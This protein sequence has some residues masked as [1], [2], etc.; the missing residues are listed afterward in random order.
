MTTLHKEEEEKKIIIPA[1]YHHNEEES[2]EAKN[3]QPNVKQLLN[4]WISILGV[5]V[6]FG[7]TMATIGVGLISFTQY[8]AGL[9]SLNIGKQTLSI[10]PDQDIIQTLDEIEYQYDDI[11]GS[12]IWELRKDIEILLERALN[13]KIPKMDEDNQAMSNRIINISSLEKEDIKEIERHIDTAINGLDE[14]KNYYDEGSGQL[15]ELERVKE[16]LEDLKKSVTEESK[17]NMDKKRI[18]LNLLIENHSSSKNGLR[19]TVVVRFYKNKKAHIPVIFF[20][21]YQNYEDILIEGN[22]FKGFRFESRL[23]DTFPKNQREF[24]Q[25]AFENQY[26]YVVALEDMKGNILSTEGTVL[27][28]KLDSQSNKLMYETERIV[29]RKDSGWFPWK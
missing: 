9:P 16:K 20:L 4:S 19:E 11:T 25:S 10:L 5:G 6:T 18:M 2:K 22:S 7:A 1:H 21:K 14:E 24:L 15:N 17:N 29:Q 3:N 27:N 28:Y 13:I 26:D 8:L 23:I 12:V